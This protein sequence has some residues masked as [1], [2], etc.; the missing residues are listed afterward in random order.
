[1]RTALSV[2]A[3]SISTENLI[4]DVVMARM[5]MLLLGQRLERL[6]RDAG[7]AAHADADHRHLGHIGR[8]VEPLIADRAL[9]LLD[10]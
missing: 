6:G 8:A 9:G 5:L 3:A 1:M 7:M 2:Y 4:S 10:A